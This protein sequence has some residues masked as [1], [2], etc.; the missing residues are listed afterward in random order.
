MT[1]YRGRMVLLFV[2]CETPI[3]SVTLGET[4]LP[5]VLQAYIAA[6]TT[7][8]SGD[9]EPV[10]LTLMP[11]TGAPLTS[12]ENN[13]SENGAPNRPARIWYLALRLSVAFFPRLQNASPAIAPFLLEVI[14]YL[15]T[16]SKLLPM[17][18]YSE[19]NGHPARYEPNV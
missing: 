10:T 2:D 19:L 6:L 1:N 4:L 16:L 7:K 12:N 13:V 3:K 5:S 8:L 11:T 14:L 17:R 9:L 18:P 15:K